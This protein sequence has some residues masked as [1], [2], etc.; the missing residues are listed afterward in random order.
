MGVSSTSN[1]QVLHPAVV[2]PLPDIV[3]LGGALAGLGGGLAMAIVAAML[4]LSLGQDLW[5]EPKVIASLLFGSGAI[6]QPGF[7]AGPALVGSLIHMLMSALL[8]ALFG[9]VTRR[10]LHLTSDFGTPLMAGVIYG[11]L[12]WAAAYFVVVPVFA[13]QLAEIY[14]P[15]F[16]VQHLVYGA[17]TGLLYTWLRPQPY[18]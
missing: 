16:I 2:S 15:S 1:R 17:V 13:P 7:V 9:I 5:H 12:I 8:G 18:A 10:V 4:S 11:L 14:A 3:G 6:A